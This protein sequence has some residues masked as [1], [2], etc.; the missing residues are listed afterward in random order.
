MKWVF[1]YQYPMDFMLVLMALKP[2]ISLLLHSYL[3]GMGWS[4]NQSKDFKTKYHS[5][6]LKAIYIESFP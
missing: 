6:A 2:M 5:L 4:Q 3:G 1:T